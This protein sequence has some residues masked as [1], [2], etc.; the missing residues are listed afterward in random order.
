MTENN[1]NSKI[2]KNPMSDKP[3]LNRNNNTGI[4]NMDNRNKTDD[5]HSQNHANAD[6]KD[7]QHEK[8]TNYNMNGSSEKNVKLVQSNVKAAEAFLNG[9]RKTYLKE[10]KKYASDDGWD[11]LQASKQDWLDS[12][13]EFGFHTDISHRIGAILALLPVIVIQDDGNPEV[14]R[15]TAIAMMLSLLDYSE[16]DR[17]VRLPNRLIRNEKADADDV[18]ETNKLVDHKRSLKEVLESSTNID[19]ELLDAMVEAYGDN[20]DSIDNINVIDNDSLS[21]DIGGVTDD[22]EEK[23]NDA[24]DSQATN[25]NTNRNSQRSNPDRNRSRNRVRGNQPN[26]GNQRNTRPAADN[27]GS[28][29]PPVK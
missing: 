16:G 10:F 9:I 5:S 17:P 25:H 29:K 26:T 6:S 23:K 28:R 19:K 22:S 24:D 15:E 20:P 12:L 2:R 14:T 1:R 3:R 7:E 11:D 21:V 8:K 4:R 27:H 18:N 13:K